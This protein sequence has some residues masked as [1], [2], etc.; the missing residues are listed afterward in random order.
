MPGHAGADGGDHAGDLA[1][2]D[3]RGGR[4]DLVA[5]LADQPVDEVDAG[6]PHVHH[7]L[8]LARGRRRPF[9]DDQRLEGSELT[10]DDG[11]HRHEPT[12]L[13]P[14]AGRSGAGRWRH[15]S[16]LSCAAPA[17]R[18]PPRRTPS[19]KASTSASVVD[20]PPTARSDRSASTPMA[21]STGEGSSDSEEH[22]EPEWT[23]MPAWSRPSSTGSASTPSTRGRRCGA[24][25]RPGSPKT[26]HP[27][28]PRGRL[29]AGRSGRR[30]AVDCSPASRARGGQGRGRGAEADGRR[31]RSPA[32]PAGPA[33]GRRR[34]G[35]ARTAAR[36]G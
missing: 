1:A 14:T 19:S 35:T 6:G 9:L 32:R 12:G 15:P 20:H 33:P 22:D 8:A 11:T 31:P 26:R 17:A 4:L 7:H 29:A 18:R 21:S 23:A 30:A 13:R 16:P 28:H 3:E 27:V 10:A 36:V 24:A 5:A 34:P 25:G 2:R